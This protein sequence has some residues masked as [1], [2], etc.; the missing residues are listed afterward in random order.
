VLLSGRWATVQLH[1]NNLTSLILLSH[2]VSLPISTNTE[3]NDFFRN[4]AHGLEAFTPGVP[5]VR[6]IS[7]CLSPVLSQVSLCSQHFI[8][9]AISPLR[10]AR[11]CS[12]RSRQRLNRLVTPSH[13]T[14]ELA[15]M[16][17]KARRGL[18]VGK[19][20]VGTL[21]KCR[22][23]AWQGKMH[24][25]SRHFIPCPGNISLITSQPSGAWR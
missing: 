23:Y 21:P 10:R 3:S 13:A 7:A 18:A 6:P 22:A 14:A 12:A 17:G 15:G 1:I 19:L 9:A 4:T 16:V 20:L 2:I 5:Q 24:D 8:I 25:R 11:P